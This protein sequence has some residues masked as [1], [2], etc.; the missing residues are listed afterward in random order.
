MNQTRKLSVG[1]L[2]ELLYGEEVPSTHDIFVGECLSCCLFRS[3][4]SGQL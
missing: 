1:N 2:G 3:E 4:T